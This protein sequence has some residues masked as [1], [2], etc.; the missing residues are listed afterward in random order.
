MNRF[1]KRVFLIV[2]L[3][4]FAWLTMPFGVGLACPCQKCQAKKHHVT[5]QKASKKHPLRAYET[6]RKAFAQDDLQAAKKASKRLQKVVKVLA[7]KEGKRGKKD[8]T[9]LLNA[10]RRIS[11][12]QK[13]ASARLAFG[14][15]SKHLIGYLTT[16]PKLARG[17]TTYQC[18][19]AKGYKKW[20]QFHSKM[21]NPY[22]GKRMLFCGG[23]T[24]LKK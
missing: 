9:G 13:I 23:K 2:A 7:K 21:G 8:L 22:M 3:L 1:P 18:P 24:N 12:S 14:R 20:V 4:T 10:A 17:A 15:L 11:K 16:H 5:N 6:L 19:M